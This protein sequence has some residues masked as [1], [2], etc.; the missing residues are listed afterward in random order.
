MTSRQ[1]LTQAGFT[2]VELAI[3]LLIVGLLIAGI[4][5]GQ[6]LIENSRTTATIQ[7]YKSYEAAVNTFRDSY[8]ALPGDIINANT[9]VPG[10]AA[11]NAVS[12]NNG[13]GGG[14]IGATGTVGVEYNNAAAGGERAQFWL[15]MALANLITGVVPDFTTN[16][17]SAFGTTVPAARLSGGFLVGYTDGAAATAGAAAGLGQMAGHYLTL[18]AS[19]TIAASQNGT[20]TAITS[21]R[22]VQMDLK[23]DDGQPGT[24]DVIAIGNA[25]NCYS[26]AGA[27]GTYSPGANNAKAC[28]LALHVV[29]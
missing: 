18:Q 27:T 22:A 16:T 20:G 14:T 21:S 6:E 1:K 28:S 25:G 10:C 19:P 15:H 2:L 9:R 17:A 26:A 4:L 3:V 24:G 11:G 8:G 23:L 29:N 13:N 5:K 7:Q 12:C